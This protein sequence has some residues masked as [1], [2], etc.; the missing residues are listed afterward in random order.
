MV[1]KYNIISS[2][3]PS[4]VGQI[5]KELVFLFFR[6]SNGDFFYLWDFT[7]D[8]SGNTDKE[9]IK[10]FVI[11]SIISESPSSKEHAQ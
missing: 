5:K 3:S 1:W 6:Q 4:V 11:P 8:L 10:T 2:I 9:I 7:T